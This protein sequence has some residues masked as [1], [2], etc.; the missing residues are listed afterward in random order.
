MESQKLSFEITPQIQRYLREILDFNDEFFAQDLGKTY[1]IETY[2]TNEK[3]SYKTERDNKYFWEY[4]EKEEIIKIIGKPK[5]K[6]VFYTDINE[7]IMV[8]DPIKF[9]IL[10]IEPIRKL[11]EKI[12]FGDKKNEIL[13]KKRGVQPIKLPSGTEWQDITIRFLDADNV[14]ITTKDFLHTTNY[15]EMGFEDKNKKMPDSQ[16]GFLQLLSSSRFNGEL[17]WEKLKE[18]TNF[19]ENISVK[20]MQ[21]FRKKKQNL[22]DILKSYF[23]IQGSP[24]YNYTKEKAY[25]IK[26]ALIRYPGQEDLIKPSEEEL[27]EKDN[28]KFY[29][30]QTSPQ[31]DFRQI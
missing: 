26:F 21:T 30:E 22:S 16:W 5:F 10:N 17:S 8:L 20:E 24:F 28:K 18:K 23:Q 7:N 4:L 2:L 11:S 31:N 19:K 29:E 12:E 14:E 9:K 15:K 3:L 1:T 13:I 25:K 6:A 27:K